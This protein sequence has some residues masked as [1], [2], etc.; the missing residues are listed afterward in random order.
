M[1]IYP[2]SVLD[3]IKDRISVAG[4]IGEKIPL[5]KAGR[6]H[7]GLCPFH[8]E[9]T[10]SFMVSDEKQMF[11]CFGCGEGGNI[12]DFLMK[13]DGLSFT[14]AVA[15]LARRAGVD[16]PEITKEKRHELDEE[17]KLK[18]WCFRLNRLVAEYYHENMQDPARGAIARKY[19][20]L[21]GI[22]TEVFT[23]HFLGYADDSW[24]H[25]RRFLVAKNVPLK[26]AAD[27]G[28]IRPR[29]DGEFYD[30]F[31]HRL[32]FPIF[33]TMGEVIGFS[34][35]TLEGGK[36]SEGREAPAKYVNS[37]DSAVY[38]KSHSLYGL[39]IALAE[40]RRLDQVIL[41]EGNVDVLSLH[42]AGFLH[43]VAPL[44]TALTSGHV[45]LLSRYTKN[46]IV[47]FDGDEAGVKAAQKSLPV[48][49]EEGLLPRVVALPSGEDPD[50]FIRKNGATEMSFLLR[51]AKALFEWLIDWTTT[52]YGR[53]TAG[54]VKAM[55]ELKPFLQ[56]ARNP[57]ERAIYQKRI[58]Q[59]LH[60]DEGAIISA[61]GGALKLRDVNTAPVSGPKVD[62]I[63]CE[64]ERMLVELMLQ[65]PEVISKVREHLEIEDFCDGS[66]KT[67]TAWLWESFDNKKDTFHIGQAIEEI[68]DLELK[69]QV[70]SLAMGEEKCD[71]ESLDDLILECVCGVKRAALDGQL[72]DINDRIEAAETE[73]NDNEMMTLM[74]EKQRLMIVKKNL[75]ETIHIR[76]A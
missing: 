11:H 59:R 34:G 13:Y 65:R 76:G 1:A 36:T 17:D 55:E 38:H 66:L 3:D 56:M 19:L 57:V 46:F 74:G 21:R 18:K 14:E 26:L 68:G 27:L 28:L 31:R 10:P 43:A 44:G 73:H 58:A 37:P 15:E 2:Q 6:N 67:I 4:F 5:K 24:D 29:R 60:V 52:R 32:M 23:Q 7:K 45:K 63:E 20:E 72:K 30:F 70:L 75:N 39:N 54:K 51:D 41:V 9:K 22:K 12:F 49:L 47:M 33:N 50:S 40:I 25:L 16:L 64:V 71:D 69:R 42:Q 8:N 53:D 48:F 62:V 35:R 61:S